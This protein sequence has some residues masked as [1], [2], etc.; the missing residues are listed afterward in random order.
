[1][2]ARAEL[3]EYLTGGEI[4]RGQAR[5]VKHTGERRG[6]GASG[7]GPRVPASGERRSVPFARFRAPVIGPPARDAGGT[8]EPP[9]GDAG[10]SG[11]GSGGNSGADTAGQGK[12][13]PQP[14]SR[15]AAIWL[16]ATFVGAVGIAVGNDLTTVF[17][18]SPVLF[19]VVLTV[20]T[21]TIGALYF[22]SDMR[23]R[24]R[25]S[26]PA[27]ID[28]SENNSVRID[29]GASMV[30]TGAA[31]TGQAGQQPPSTAEP[32][33]GSGRAIGADDVAEP[34]P[35]VR[36]WLIVF[37]VALAMSV[38]F[39]YGFWV[40]GNGFAHSSVLGVWGLVS[41]VVVLAV[42]MLL[43]RRLRSAPDWLAWLRAWRNGVLAIGVSA[44][45][46][47]SGATL[48]YAQLLP[49]PVA[50]APCPAPTELRVLAAS[51]V[52]GP[53]QAAITSYEQD[54][55]S[56]FASSC[57]AVDITAYAAGNDKAA[58]DGIVGGWNLA[59]GP[60]PDV[61]VP[62][63]VEELPV[64]TSPVDNPVLDPR[65]S[66]ATSPVVVAVPSGFVTPALA[67]YERNH[68]L[69]DIYE[70]IKGSLTLQVPNP[71]LSETARLG[72]A[73]L[74][75]ALSEAE[76]AQIGDSVSF[77]TD[78]GNL[79]CQ[80]APAKPTAYLVSNVTVRQN[81]DGDLGASAC[82]GQQAAQGQLTAFS[83]ANGNGVVL[84]F[85]YTTVSWRDA[86]PSA[87]KVHAEQDFY[88]WLIS[89]AGR[90]ALTAQG[91]N[92]PGL[93][94]SL[95]SPDAVDAAVSGFTRVQPSAR[96]LIA[97]DDSMPMRP[98]LGQIAQATDAVLGPNGQGGNLSGRDSFGI[99]AFPSP[100]GATEKTLV[101]LGTESAAQRG[102]VPPAVAAIAGRGHSAE[103]DL[104]Y[105][106]AISL[107]S[108]APPGSASSLVILTDGDNQPTDPGGKDMAAITN[109]LAA[110][111]PGSLPIKVY[112]IA[113]GPAG[114]AET[115]SGLS[116]DSL[117]ALAKAGGGTC[118]NAA[119]GSLQ[120]QL[121]Q[122]ISALSTGG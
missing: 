19:I 79:L 44:I 89:E 92:P 34:S 72:I 112:V 50:A 12:P 105:D 6:M 95:P 8:A 25:S 108:Q 37:C 21:I 35:A 56:R 116:G 55:R 49:G 53:L 7:D 77:P 57:Y 91:L 54:E 96:I 70:A 46:L 42:V 75:P 23:D 63:S 52:L 40:I 58:D 65:G 94:P 109:L 11:A 43:A 71:R 82:P 2:P 73:D 101:P 97:I 47:S 121:A 27:E 98:Y 30:K 29:A 74:Y 28:T 122:D 5:M 15:R 26:G 106:A 62:A 59:D 102:R 64:K 32:D 66:I 1:M 39:A 16:A 33:R 119:G 93:E 68:S 86:K 4:G 41:V 61:W 9:A 80:S 114:C 84:D 17:A 113:F 103:F 18:H 100:S 10:N 36:W 111:K 104:V 78:S 117:N 14:D 88:N 85:P 38:T 45:G 22:F 24:L 107:S 48:G 110:Q 99:W 90:K 81:N 60:R 13:D 3:P 76:Q 120:Q 118:A 67:Q 87:A 31:S 51:E 69:S 115:P 20:V 83:P